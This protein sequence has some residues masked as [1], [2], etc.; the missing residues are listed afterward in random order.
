MVIAKFEIQ[1]FGLASEFPVSITIDELLKMIQDQFNETHN[2]GIVLELIQRLIT[3]L[4]KADLID[5]EILNL[6]LKEIYESNTS[7]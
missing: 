3:M 4:R 2:A 5:K 7:L 1:G 6:L